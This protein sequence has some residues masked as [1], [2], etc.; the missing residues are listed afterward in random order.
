MWVY[1]GFFSLVLSFIV[2]IY[3]IVA[4]LYG[5]SRKE[6]RWIES[7][8]NAMILTFPL[9]TVS[10]ISIVVLLVSDHF[11]VAYVAA[12]TSRSMP[13]YLKITALWGGQEGSLILWSWLMAFFAFIVGL[14]KW[15]RD[16]EYL[17]W[18][19]I[20]NLITIGFFLSLSL[21]IENPFQQLWYDPLTY[22][23]NPV[24]AE[25][26]FKPS[27]QVLAELSNGNG[28]NPL[29]RHPG[30]IIHPPMLY[31]GF[32]SFVIPFAFGIAALMTGRTDDRWIKLTR[33][34]TLWAWLF[35]SL[36]LILGMRWAYD[37]LGWGGY[38]AWDPVENAALL[39][40]LTGTAFLH[41]VMIQEKRNMFK[42]WNMVLIMMTYGLVIYGTFLTRS[43]VMSSVHAFAQS[44][45]G[46]VFFVFLT[47][48]AAFCIWL[49]IKRWNSLKTETELHSWF[50]REALFLL[51]NLLFVSIT[52]IVFLGIHYPILTEALGLIGDRIPALS[53]IFTGQ[54][55]TV[56]AQF[57]EMATGPIWAAIVLLMGVA[58]LS[59]WRASTGR[60]LGKHIWKPSALAAAVTVLIYILGVHQWAAL[61][62]F[63]FSTLVVF[64]TVYEFWRASVAR[65]RAQNEN[66]LVSFYKLFGKN[67]RRYGG[68]LIHLGVVLMALGIIGIEIFQTDTQQRLA[69]G[70]QMNLGD[71]SVEYKDMSIFLTDDNKQV[72]RAVVDIYKGD[73]YLGEL[74]PRV[75]LYYEFGQNMTI[76][77]VRSTLEDDLYVILVEWEEVSQDFATFKVYHNPLINWLWI[78]GF[79]LIIGVLVAAW[80]DNKAQQLLANPR[81][82][83]AGA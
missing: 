58:P 43:G 23:L 83:K 52:I 3:G 32:V 26:V 21:F 16:R 48:S 47:A 57:Y 11:E 56:G 51:N 76:P 81:T 7:A 68:Y 78:G 31:L 82:A 61:L 22:D 60:S 2:S 34:Y 14:R 72:S 18:I 33:R 74:Y 54:K 36:G 6:E 8:K 63:L 38:W 24:L 27:G 20:V 39:P 10:V 30:M 77:G 35:L 71:Y 44:A 65:S 40:W 50:S 37:V 45:L 17:P 13:L 59:A 4:A 70:E 29:L 75:D 28:L 55:V 5:N 67:R 42:Q 25:A 73:E 80:P 53:H 15:D 69:L 9:L 64:V 62:G 1:T 79:V 46:P 19:V 12:V 41:S 49:L 66:L